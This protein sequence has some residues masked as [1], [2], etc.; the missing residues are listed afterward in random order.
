MVA[1]PA[2]PPSPAVVQLAPKADRAFVGVL[3]ALTSLLAARLLLLLAIAGALVLALLSI[4]A[5]FLARSGRAVRFLLS[6][7]DPDDL[8][9][10]RYASQRGSVR[11]LIG[12]AETPNVTS[13]RP[14]HPRKPRV[15]LH[16]PPIPPPIAD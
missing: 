3:A 14:G 5:E 10:C 7:R 8:P 16:M 1:D 2:P 12:E 11:C 9:G 4:R 15:H 6:D 13:E